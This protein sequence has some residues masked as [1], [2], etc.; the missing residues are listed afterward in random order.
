MAY[1]VVE[2]DREVTRVNGA[3]DKPLMTL[4]DEYGGRAQIVRDD[5]C[6]MVLLKRDDGYK[7]TAW[8]FDEAARAI[9]DLVLASKEV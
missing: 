3:V 8:I 7:H 4:A 9:S 2:T 6:Y 1:E 5:N